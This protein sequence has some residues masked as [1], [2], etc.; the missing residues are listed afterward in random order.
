[1]KKSALLTT[2]VIILS[3]WS[4]SSL[5]ANPSAS[6]R[7]A[8]V[9]PVY[10]TVVDYHEI[11][12]HLSLIG[13]L[14]SDQFVSIATQVS[15]KVS[16]INVK[17]NQTVKE[18]QLLFKLDD[19]KV[20]AALLEAKAYLA[21]ELR[22]LNEHE[23]LVKSNTVTQSALDA[24]IVQVDIA[25]ARLTS[26]QTDVNYHYL[27]APFSGTIG[28]LDFS[29]GQIVSIGSEML[30]LDDLSTMTLDLQ[31]PEHYLSQLS[32]GM[33]VSATNRAWPDTQ[34]TGELVAI[35][36]RINPDTLN[37]RIRVKFDNQDK[38]L[39]PGMLMSAKIAFPVINEPIIPV[40]AIEYSGTKRF[41]YRITDKN[42]VQR[43]EVML[44]G[45]VEDSVL[46]ESG[47]KVGDKI[48]VQ[49]LV[50]MSDGL[51]VKDLSIEDISVAN[52][53]GKQQT[54]EQPNQETK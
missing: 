26:I 16:T 44:G 49:G 40:Q 22:K 25:K 9:I 52:K 4:S 12:Q 45:R 13:K 29:R 1:M 5:F 24:Q 6:K 33:Q 35:D 27:K 31:V 15:G 36:S 39:K 20:Q 47:V 46:I 21:D 7:S 54:T 11:T 42:T 53:K 43:T 19:K 8:P 32:R 30:T 28:L 50:N 51:K 48:V 37:L 41:V 17:A 14:Q 18:G 10:S 3:T 23:R 2:V 38:S 34:F